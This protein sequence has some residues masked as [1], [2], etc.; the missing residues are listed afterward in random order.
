MNVMN[1]RVVSKTNRTF[2]NKKYMLKKHEQF[3]NTRRYAYAKTFCYKLI[4]FLC[5]MYV[6]NIWLLDFQRKKS[7]QTF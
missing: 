6:L 2:L 3:R 4:S 1:L 7:T 5:V